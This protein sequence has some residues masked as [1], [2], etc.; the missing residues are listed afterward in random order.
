MSTE[1]V[2]YGSSGDLD[3]IVFQNRNRE[4]GAYDLRKVYKNYLTKSVL[5]GTTLFVLAIVVPFTYAKIKEANKVEEKQVSVNLEEIYDQPKEE[6]QEE[7]QEAAPPPPPKQEE[8]KQ[9]IIKDVIPEPKVNAQNE[10][11]PPKLAE[12]LTTTT[13]TI[14]QEGEKTVTYHRPEPAGVPGGTGTKPV[15]VEVKPKVS[16]QEVYQEVDQQ[17]DFAG[18]GI[19]AFRS[20]FQDNFD[21]SAVE[22]EGSLKTTVSFTVERDG[23]LTDVKATGSNSDFNR[24][25]ERAVKAIKGKWNPGKVD[26]QAVRS[27]FRFPITMN[28]E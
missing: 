5:I 13:G 15:P 2:Q 27:K 16:E 28:F 14:N 8:V 24:E 10:A 3:E 19:N 26:G 1:N 12:K 9:E 11:P 6:Q 20:R 25:A 17:A 4:Y 18:G 22:G 7:K 21:S 23:S